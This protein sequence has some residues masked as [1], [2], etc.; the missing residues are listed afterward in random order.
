MQGDTFATL[1][2]V[3]SHTMRSSEINECASNHVGRLAKLLEGEIHSRIAIAMQGLQHVSL[4]AGSPSLE[5][6]CGRRL[7][8]SHSIIN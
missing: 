8:L 1:A 4:S 7:A 6:A 2:A 5:R 3:A